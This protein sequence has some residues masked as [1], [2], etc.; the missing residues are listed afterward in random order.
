MTQP[1]T[2][3][4]PGVLSVP[5]IVPGSDLTPQEDGK[6]HD[7]LLLDALSVTGVVPVPDSPSQDGMVIDILSGQT[8]LTA[9]PY[10]CYHSCPSNPEYQVTGYLI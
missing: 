10:A 5:G 6:V 2:H 1:Q 8:V 7:T 3:L 4:L 9:W